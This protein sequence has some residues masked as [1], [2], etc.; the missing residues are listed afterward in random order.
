M[1]SLQGQSIH[2]EIHTSI[3]WTEAERKRSVFWCQL[4]LICENLQGPISVIFYFTIVGINRCMV[5]ANTEFSLTTYRNKK[6]KQ[7]M[8]KPLS[9]QIS[10]KVIA[11]FS[12]IFLT[13]FR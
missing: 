5:F 11:N 3:L 4:I 6:A 10:A 8:L 9:S 2:T 13:I 7:I 12:L 1:I